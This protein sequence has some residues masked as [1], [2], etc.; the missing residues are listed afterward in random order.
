MRT[1]LRTRLSGPRHAFAPLF[2]SCLATL[3]G[4]GSSTSSDAPSGPSGASAPTGAPPEPQVEDERPWTPAEVRAG[5]ADGSLPERMELRDDLVVEVQRAGLGPLCDMYD[6]VSIHYDIAMQETGAILDSSR[7]R[8]TPVFSELGSGS[9]IPGLERA[10]L[11]LRVGTQ[12]RI[13]VPAFLGYGEQGS[14]VQRI[15]GN[16]DLL[17]DAEVLLVR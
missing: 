15:P 14:A 10:L 7:Q 5:R 4:C 16:A 8:G 13:L 11:G 17:I 3:A 12:V 2:L 6:T 9:W 1:V